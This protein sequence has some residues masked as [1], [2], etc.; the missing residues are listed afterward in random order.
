MDKIMRVSVSD[1]TQVRVTCRKCTRPIVIEA[2]LEQLSDVLEARGKCRFCGHE[3]FPQGS[4][5][6]L[7]QLKLTLQKLQQNEADLLKIEFD[8]EKPAS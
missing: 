5:D 6:L 1:L 2:R 3:H 7:R 4:D 8:L